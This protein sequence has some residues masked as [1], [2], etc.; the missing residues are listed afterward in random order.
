MSIGDLSRAG[1]FVCACRPVKEKQKRVTA[2]IKYFIVFLFKDTEIK[3]AINHLI[4]R[5]RIFLHREKKQHNKPAWLYNV[6]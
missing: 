3:A 1:S 2:R 5:R 6:Y 4:D